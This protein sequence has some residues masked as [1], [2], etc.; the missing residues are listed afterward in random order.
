MGRPRKPVPNKERA[1]GRLAE[2][3]RA[4]QG[5]ARLTLGQI[6]EITAYGTTTLQ[7]AVSGITVPTFPVVLAFARACE[8]D[9]EI[10]HSLWLQA[11]AERNRFTRGAQ[12]GEAPH[13]E[14][15]R[16]RADLSAA[17]L[18]LH[19]RQGCPSVREMERRAESRRKD[20]GGLSRSSAHRIIRRQAVPTSRQQLMAFLIACNC[21]EGEH[22]SWVR[23]WLRAQQ[24]HEEEAA[25]MKDELRAL[26]SDATGGYFRR[27]S[28]PEAMAMLRAAGMEPK[29]A[30]HGFRQPWTS[31]CTNCGNISRVRLS[32]IARGQ[33]GCQICCRGNS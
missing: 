13:L 15:V 33:G 32:S 25:R 2:Y 5:E 19:E 4:G 7:R 20:F 24:R 3:L 6:G 26:E 14:L 30:Y 11:R 10:A 8:L 29:E 23:A 9:T 17:L 27:L 16:D 31:R 12:H 21:P 22:H 1:S 18:A 28:A